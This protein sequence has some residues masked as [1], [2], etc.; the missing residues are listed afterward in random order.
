MQHHQQHAQQPLQQAPPPQQQQ[1]QQQQMQSQ[2]QQQQQ[3]APAQAAQTTVAA[4]GG[5]GGGA[6]SQQQLQRLYQLVLDL[7]NSEKREAALLEL[8]KKREEFPDLAPIL[9]HTFG[10]IAALLQEIISI[11]P[12]LS[13]RTLLPRGCC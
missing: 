7:T 13:V 3:Q 2:H 8:S 4:G 11:Y 1:Q 6:V 12:L 10:T 5:V 9:W